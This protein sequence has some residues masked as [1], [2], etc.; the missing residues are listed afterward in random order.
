MT[1]LDHEV[2]AF[3]LLLKNEQKV[4]SSLIASYNV[5]KADWN[6]FMKNLQSNYAVAKLKIQILIQSPNIKNLEKMAIL[7]RLTI[8]NAIKENI[9]KRRSCNQSKV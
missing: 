6:N 8:E 3:N 5:Q 4:D 9:S 1:R 2:I 7:L